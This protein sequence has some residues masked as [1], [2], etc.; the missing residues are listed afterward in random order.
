M[1]IGEKVQRPTAP[2]RQNSLNLWGREADTLP[3]LQFS[4]VLRHMHF[5]RASVPFRSA[6]T[7]FS[8]LDI[9]LRLP[10]SHRAC[11]VL[12]TP[13]LLEPSQ[14]GDS[15]PMIGENEATSRWPQTTLKTH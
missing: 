13:D 11:V 10:T 4:L 3:R 8:R 6:A 1:L 12:A 15:T 5:R 9:F 7:F 2:S 14:T